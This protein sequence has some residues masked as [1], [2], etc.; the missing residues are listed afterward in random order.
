MAHHNL[1]NISLFIPFIH[2]QLSSSNIQLTASVR[3][4]KSGAFAAD[5]GASKRTSDFVLIG[6]VLTRT[7]NGLRAVFGNVCEASARA[8]GFAAWQED[9]PRSRQL[10]K[11]SLMIFVPMRTE[12]WR[13]GTY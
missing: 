7:S 8:T 10:F 13:L 5:F 6:R 3:A 11:V 9:R 2:P 1:I 4:L 12:T